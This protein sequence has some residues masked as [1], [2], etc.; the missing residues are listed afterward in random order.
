L[1]QAI[2]W[3]L[4]HVA[5]WLIMFFSIERSNLITSCA[6]EERS[7]LSI[8]LSHPTSP[9]LHSNTNYGSRMQRCTLCKLQSVTWD[10]WIT[11]P[12][13][14]RKRGRQQGQIS[15]KP[16]GTAIHKTLIRLWRSPFV[17]SHAH[18]YKCARNSFLDFLLFYAVMAALYYLKR[19]CCCGMCVSVSCHLNMYAGR[20]VFYLE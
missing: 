13:K 8:F 3:L 1:P 20:L 10:K 11:S 14:K 4:S 7:F 9:G 12:R 19:W 2:H 6:R 17:A 18:C 15:L 16:F 5:S